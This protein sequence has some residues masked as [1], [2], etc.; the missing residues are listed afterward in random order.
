MGVDYFSCDSCRGAASE[1]DEIWCEKCE[2]QLCSCAMPQELSEIM[3]CWEDAWKYI[4]VDKDNQIQHNASSKEDYTEIFRKYLSSN[5][6]YGLVLKEE[7][8]PVC[9][10]RKEMEKDPEYREYLRLKAKFDN[11]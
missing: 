5:D 1:Y 7:Y 9:Q 11:Y 3:E 10:R 2:S 4:G 6:D 8:C